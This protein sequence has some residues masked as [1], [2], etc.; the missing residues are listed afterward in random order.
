MWMGVGVFVCVCEREREEVRGMGVSARV[1]VCMYVCVCVCVYVC[2]F[3]LCFCLFVCVCKYMCAYC[4]VICIYGSRFSNKYI[5]KIWSVDM[6]L[7]CDLNLEF[8]LVWAGVASL[9]KGIL[10]RDES[11]GSHSDPI[12]TKKHNGSRNI[13]GR[14]RAQIVLISNRSLQEHNTT[15]PT[16]K[17]T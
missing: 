12:N 17:L 9:G 2:V 6:I 10:R 3:C 11:N 1:F 8:A 4:A 13:L 7:E 14:A 16:T 5:C 15:R